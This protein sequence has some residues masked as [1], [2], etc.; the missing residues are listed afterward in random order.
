MAG[1]VKKSEPGV[2]KL[3]LTPGIEYSCTNPPIRTH[4]SRRRFEYFY[5]RF[6]MFH[7]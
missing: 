2:S 1:S 3:T 5:D 6:Y 7:W 4:Q